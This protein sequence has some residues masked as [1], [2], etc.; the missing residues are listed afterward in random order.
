MAL[1]LISGKI[2][3]PHVF[4]EATLA[5]AED[6]PS[7]ASSLVVTL[8]RGG[9]EVSMATTTSANAK[10]PRFD[11]PLWIGWYGEEGVDSSSSCSTVK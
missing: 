9:V 8:V 1:E 7:S 6:F 3:P 2:F 5:E 11:H 10:G 4:A